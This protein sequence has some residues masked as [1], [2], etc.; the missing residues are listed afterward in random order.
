MIYIELAI[1][2]ACILIGARKGAMGLG[3][4]GGVGLLILVFVFKLQPTSP[5]IDVMLIII[6]VVTAASTLQATKGMDYLVQIAEKML[7]KNPSRITYMAPIVMYIFTICA[8]TGN[9]AFALIPVVAEVARE[10]GVRPE[11]PL[12]IGIIA[13]Q[14]AITACP[15]SAA[16]V[17]LLAML[18]PQGITLFDILKV[19]IPATI[20]SVLIAAF[21]VSKKGK[22]LHLDEEYQRRVREGLI[23]PVRTGEPVYKEFSKS[24]KLSVALFIGAALIVTLVGTVQSLRPVWIVDGSEVR[25]SMTLAIEIV[26]LTAAAA[27][28]TFCKPKVQDIIDSDVFRT[29]MASVIAI[30]GVAWLGDTFFQNNMAQIK[31]ALTEMVTAYPFLF[32]F[33]LF[34]LSAMLFSQAATV[35]A[36]MPLGIALGIPAPALIAMFPAVNGYFVVPC[37]G[38]IVAGINFDRTG[39]TRIGKYLFNHSFM[40]PGLI[41]CFFSVLIGYGLMALFF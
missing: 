28:L 29:G 14:Q 41:A 30:F 34:I 9:I 18:S 37:Y 40:V 24:A 20:I 26:M 31:G 38:T 5:P 6:S 15:I 12:S 2:L 36:L 3:F 4:Y 32:A 10:S 23:P 22:E 39:T 27:I 7:R 35:R 11:R 16:T 19:C 21:L 13:S 1:V 8:G 33:A 17:T 25:L